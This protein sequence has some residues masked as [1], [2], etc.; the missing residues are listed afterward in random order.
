MFNEWIEVIIRQI[1]NKL[2]SGDL[3]E[4]IA[5]KY[6]AAGMPFGFVSGVKPSTRLIESELWR[7]WIKLCIRYRTFDSQRIQ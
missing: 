7:Q 3:V 1:F 4:Y 5:N 6:N 2:L